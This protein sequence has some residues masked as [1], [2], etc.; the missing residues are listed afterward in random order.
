M[1]I[2]PSILQGKGVTSYTTGP[3]SSCGNVSSGSATAGPEAARKP[4]Y[5]NRKTAVQ[6][7]TFDSEREAKRYIQLGLMQ[8]CGAICNLRTQVKYR[9]V[10]NG[11]LICTYKADFVYH[12]LKDG[13]FVH[14][15]VEDVKGFPNDR[16]PMKKK[17]MRACHGI[18]VQEV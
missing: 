10:V 6:G 12:L 17:L 8:K 15:V 7:R 3:Q 13:E 1:K 9:C 18:V 4:K 5:G 11:V 14:E 16:W 2:D